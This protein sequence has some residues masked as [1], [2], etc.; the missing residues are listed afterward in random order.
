M[1]EFELHEDRFFD[2]DPSIRSKARELY[3]TVKEYPIVSPHGHVDPKIFVDNSPFPNPVE[4]FITPDHYVF[5]ML[6]S[7]G[8]S[9]KELNIPDKNGKQLGKDPR[10]VWQLFGDYYY[11]FNGT[12]TGIWLDYEFKVV[13]GIKGKFNGKN[14]QM[15][16][17]IINARLETEEFLPR[18]LFDQFN[19]EVL[20][21]T[22]SATDDQ[23]IINIFMSP[24]GMERLFHVFDLML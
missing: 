1:N 10:E 16:Y 13:F 2:P 3:E 11:L 18:N 19:I 15:F 14:A 8:I 5:R 21:T 7:Q 23:N 12:P 9:L 17:D 22:D 4:L 6:Y 20:S 24:N